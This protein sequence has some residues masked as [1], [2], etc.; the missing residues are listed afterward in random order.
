MVKLR[1]VLN[2]LTSE[3]PADKRHKHLEAAEEDGNYHYMR[4][5]KLGHFDSLADRNRK[6]VHS[7]RNTREKN[8]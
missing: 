4:L 8:F 1:Y 7:E 3:Q 2:E 5:A 6:G